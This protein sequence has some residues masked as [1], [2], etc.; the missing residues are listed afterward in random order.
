M[1]D[2]NKIN[3]KKLA[4]NLKTI[5]SKILNMSREQFEISTG[6]SYA[7]LRKIEN[8]EYVKESTLDKLTHAL[9]KIGVLASLCDNLS[10]WEITK[11]IKNHDRKNAFLVR[12][13]SFVQHLKII[14]PKSLLIIYTVN[15][16]ARH[17]QKNTILIG[18]KKKSG[19]SLYVGFLCIVGFVK[20]IGMPDVSHVILK[21]ASLTTNA[22]IFD[23]DGKRLSLQKAEIDFLAPVFCTYYPDDF[24]EL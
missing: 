21:L 2:T 12:R 3:R 4:E 8:E 7:T 5:R 24:L 1:A 11:E 19:F 22:L 10:T 18:L 15:K 13:N 14:Y 23:D 16:D 20:R 9:K 17:F 6:F